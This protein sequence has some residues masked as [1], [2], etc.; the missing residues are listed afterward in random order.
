MNG[1]S[2]EKKKKINKKKDNTRAADELRS[3]VQIPFSLLLLQGIVN[4]QD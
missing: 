3:G 1:N 2:T 4:I